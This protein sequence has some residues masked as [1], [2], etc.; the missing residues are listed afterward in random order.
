MIVPNQ[1]MASSLMMPSDFNEKL[2]QG[3]LGEKRERLLALLLQERKV[4]RII[5]APAGMG[6]SSLA[7]DYACTVFGLERTCWVDGASAVFLTNLDDGLEE[8]LLLSTMKSG[9][10]LVIDDLPHLDEER[11]KS[12]SM[13]I[14]T[15]IDTGWEVLV[16]SVP[17]NDS[18]SSL[19]TDCLMLDSSSLLLRETEKKIALKSMSAS[20]AEPLRNALGIPVY[21]ATGLLKGHASCIEAFLDEGLPLR[22]HQAAI[23]MVFLGSGA[24]QDLQS[25]GIILAS[26][27]EDLLSKA[28]LFLGFDKLTG[29]FK[30]PALPIQSLKSILDQHGGIAGYNILSE[31]LFTIIKTLLYR[32]E[33][34]RCLGILDSFCSDELKLIW[35]NTAC[36]DLIDSGSVA[37]VDEL[38]A[39]M[40]SRS[41]WLNDPESCGT[42]ACLALANGDVERAGDC[43]RTAIELIRQEEPIERYALCEFPRFQ[44]VLFAL[45]LFFEESGSPSGFGDREGSSQLLDIIT[46]A[47]SSSQSPAG[48]LMS[49]A[50]LFHMVKRQSDASCGKLERTCSVE[51]A[52]G[53][54]SLSGTPGVVDENRRLQSKDMPDSQ[55][56][57][58][59]GDQQDDKESKNLSSRECILKALEQSTGSERNTWQFRLTLHL[60]AEVIRCD[61]PPYTRVSS[62]G[63]SPGGSSSGSFETKVRLQVLLVDMVNRMRGSSTLVLT[64]ALLIYDVESFGTLISPYRAGAAQFVELRERAMEILR[65]SKGI[66]V[67]LLAD[68]ADRLRG[69]I[70]HSGTI[71]DTVSLHSQSPKSSGTSIPHVAIRI[72]GGF[73]VL[74]DDVPVDTTH[75]NRRKARG[76][77]SLLLL[78]LGKDVPREQILRVLWPD[79]NGLRMNDSLYASWS[80]LRSL[81]CEVTGL[82]ECPYLKKSGTLYRVDKRYLSSDVFEYEELSKRLIMAPGNSLIRGQAKSSTYRELLDRDQRQWLE[83]FLRLEELYRGDLLADKQVNEYFSSCRQRYEN[84]T[85]ELL[86]RGSSYAISVGN[87]S[88][89]AWFAQ[90][91]LEYGGEREETYRALIKAQTADGQR[92]AALETYE[93]CRLFMKNAMGLS[94]SSKTEVLYQDLLCEDEYSLDELISPRNEHEVASLPQDTS[95]REKVETEKEEVS[96]CLKEDSGGDKDTRDDDSVNTKDDGSFSDSLG[97]I[98]YIDEIGNDKEE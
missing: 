69:R 98:L 75:W 82:K 30:S 71:N 21:F 47:I 86:L 39:T 32:R 58:V 4:L 62:R 97:E 53:Y 50:A 29:R 79:S 31:H 51:N 46:D 24:R 89:S 65:I 87:S 17:S 41:F 27:E 92:T 59:I 94:P 36:P 28:Y 61:G 64:E 49:A 11:T 44:R 78:N 37:L 63:E 48:Y 90:Q 13:T 73:E 68:S 54:I 67:V 18:L 84:R 12:L 96:G 72:F 35:L 6:K 7:M 22:F 81:M 9:S 95:L 76:L 88:V 33:G 55:A 16:T 43:I 85:I 20:V 2:Y 52:L 25:L 66:G 57:F 34:T 14:D 45:Q 15:L 83:L 26:D 23:A 60:F 91:A 93:K 74:V 80:T 3:T 5:V 42:L 38:M 70:V 1:T 10:L 8:R 40:A 77:L 56:I 19:Q